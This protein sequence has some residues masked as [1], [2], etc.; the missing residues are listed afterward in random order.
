MTD[1]NSRLVLKDVRIVY[2]H[3]FQKNTYLNQETAYD[4]WFLISKDDKEQVNKVLNRIATMQ[5]EAN[6][7]VLPDKIC[8][9]D[10]D[11]D[12]KDYSFNHWVLKVS[13]KKNP[14]I[15]LH[16]S[17]REA[18]EVDNP[19]YG[20]CY[21]NVSFDLWLQNNQYGKRING[22]LFAVMFSKDG[23][24]IGGS[25]VSKKDIENDFSDFDAQEDDFS[26][27]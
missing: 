26:D 24:K 19:V 23:E 15:V 25:S 22:N 5:K 16:A 6:V 2:P 20:G 8:F 17:K 3:L 27:F 12:D 21:V 14:P 9:K 13:S 11:L 7:K 1:N 4:A 18:T 10:G